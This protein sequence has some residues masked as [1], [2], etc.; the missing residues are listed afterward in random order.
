MKLTVKT[1]KGELIELD[2]ELNN[3]VHLF[4]IKDFGFEK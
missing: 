4:M 1:L 3:T 2:A